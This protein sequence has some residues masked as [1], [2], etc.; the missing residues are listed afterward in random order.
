MSL[1]SSLSRRSRSSFRT[2]TGVAQ[3]ALPPYVSRSMRLPQPKASPTRLARVNLFPR[4][5]HHDLDF[6]LGKNKQVSGRIVAA[7][8]DIPL[9]KCLALGDAHDPVDHVL[10]QS[11]EQIRLSDVHGD[12]VS[13]MLG[14]KGQIQRKMNSIIV[15]SM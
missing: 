7:K 3:M 1:S 14:W 12:L 10:V 8:Q 6:T 11:P 4:L 13:A 5:V 9:G 2:T 15:Y